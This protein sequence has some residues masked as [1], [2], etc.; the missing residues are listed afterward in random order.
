M[1]DDELRALIAM[2][3]GATSGPW[4]TNSMDCLVRFHENK[5]FISSSRSALPA[6]AEEVLRLREQLRSA[7]LLTKALVTNGESMVSRDV[8]AESSHLREETGRLRQL[9]RDLGGNADG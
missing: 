6:L 5:V 2:A 8:M 3:K 1:T 9:I 4:N 7:A